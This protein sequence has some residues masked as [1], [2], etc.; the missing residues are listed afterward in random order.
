[1]Y[2]FGSSRAATKSAS[3]RNRNRNKKKR[4]QEQSRA[5]IGKD[6]SREEKREEQRRGEKSRAEVVGYGV[7]RVRGLPSRGE[8]R[9]RTTREELT[10]HDIGHAQSGVRGHCEIV[11][12]A[13]AKSGPFEH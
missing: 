7:R 5:E 6:K 8:G 11:A 3:Q 13:A 10:D 4:R 12:V 2:F 1:M 9:S